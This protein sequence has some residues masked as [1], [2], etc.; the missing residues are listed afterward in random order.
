MYQSLKNKQRIFSIVGGFVKSTVLCFSLILTFSLISF[1]QTTDVEKTPAYKFLV[2]EK[3]K[4][5]AELGNLR[6]MYTDKH[7]D[8][9]AKLIEVNIMETEMAKLSYFDKAKY[10]LLSECYGKLIMEKVAIESDLRMALTRFKIQH[11]VVQQK[12]QSLVALDVK[13]N[14][15]G[16]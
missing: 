15:Y 13:I 11:P 8:V 7:P 14:S 10:A 2:A 16:Q 3:V 12:V 5:N 9:Q 4:L 6:Q 1:G